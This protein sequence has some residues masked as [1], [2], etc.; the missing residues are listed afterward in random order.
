M[1]MAR[2]NSTA[3]M[4]HTFAGLRRGRNGGS[5]AKLL[6]RSS[7][8]GKPRSVPKSGERSAFVAGFGAAALP[9]ASS[10]TFSAAGGSDDKEQA[11][12]LRH[13]DQAWEHCSQRTEDYLGKATL[14]P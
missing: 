13:P 7:C 1:P 11:A 5:C 3:A 10:P 6:S 4:V 2:A 14:S 12:E 8:R 9:S